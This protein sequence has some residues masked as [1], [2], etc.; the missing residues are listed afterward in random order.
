MLG[1]VWHWTADAEFIRKLEQPARRAISWVLENIDSD[2]RGYVAYETRST[3]G[4]QNHAWKDSPN[5]VLFK[6]GQKAEPPVSIYEVQGYAYDAL[7]RTA[8]LAERVWGDEAFAEMLRE[9]AGALKA[10]FDRDFWMEGRGYYA[11][12]L[13]G[14]GHRVDPV[15]SNAGH[16]FWG[17]IVPEEKA[18]AIADKLLGL[19]LFS[20]WGIRTM[21]SSEGGHD[22]A[23]YHNGSVWSHD[24]AIIAEGMKRYG[25]LEEAHRVATA[26]I[27]AAPHFRYRLPEVFAGHAREDSGPVQLP[28]SCSLQAWAAGTVPLLAKTLFG[29]EPGPKNSWSSPG[30]LSRLPGTLI[31]SVPVSKNKPRSKG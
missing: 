13:D 1:E 20:G 12:A 26:L 22:P 16:L 31:G 4:L 2:E 25:F 11:L 19:E 14:Y 6:D 30:P 5:S 23:S 28:V 18:R 27:Q 21:A 29:I 3:A 15:T 8:V 17:G 10:R 24:N 7:M 9:R